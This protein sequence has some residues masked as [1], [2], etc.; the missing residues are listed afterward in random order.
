[1]LSKAEREF[2]EGK[3][4]VSDSYRRY[5]IH[6]IRRKLKEA[7]RDIELIGESQSVRKFANEIAEVARACFLPINHL[8]ST[9]K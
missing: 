7:A 4:K 9:K 8:T 2:L 1:M 5:L 6:N 3:K